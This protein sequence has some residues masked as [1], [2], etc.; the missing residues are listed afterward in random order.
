MKWHSRYPALFLSLVLLLG[1]LC[2]SCT[3]ESPDGPDVDWAHYLGDPGSRQYSDINQITT[4]NVHRLEVA[5]TYDTG[6]SAMY[7]ANNLIIDGLLYTPTPTR[8]VT[9]LNAA[10]GEHIWTFEPNSVHETVD[11]GQQRGLMYWAS[12][13]STDRRVL[14]VKGSWL[15]ALDAK[16]GELVDSFGE[17]GWIHLGD[18]M[19]VK[20]RPQVGLNTPGYVYNDLIIAGANVGEDVPG[21]IR[22]FDVQ[23]GERR[24][25]FHTLPRPGQP[26]SET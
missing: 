6:D 1:M 2:T 11:R 14:T 23:T 10:T 9:A 21:A 18:G 19:D 12:S 5:W 17:G 24:W 7:Q 26:G 25:I 16:T 3:S 15:Y 4:E 13:D 20:G 8:N 22:A